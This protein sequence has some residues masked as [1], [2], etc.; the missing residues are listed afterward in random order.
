MEHRIPLERFEALLD[1]YGAQPHK[2][3]ADERAAAHALLA[4][5]ADARAALESARALDELLDRASP[6]P[7]LSADLAAKIL[8]ARPLPGG[9]VAPAP[10]PEPPAL[11]PA[12][13]WTSSAD[14]TR[15]ARHLPHGIL[16]M[17]AKPRLLPMAALA[18]S[19]ALGLVSGA[20]IKSMM[21]TTVTVAY[22][23]PTVNDLFALGFST[24]MSILPSDLR[25]TI[26]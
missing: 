7:A 9:S 10:L 20:L 21:P 14:I 26:E 5:S 22:G 3:P 19:L 18:A 16:A 4:Q 13:T 12:I 8:A 11:D 15:N 25:G 24:Q 6:V 17:I 2:W 23:A 1:L